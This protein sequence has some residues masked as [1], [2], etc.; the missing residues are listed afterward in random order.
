MDAPLDE[1]LLDSDFDEANTKTVDLQFDLICRA[2]VARVQ[3]AAD[4]LVEKSVS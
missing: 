3:A 2:S 1:S 4:E